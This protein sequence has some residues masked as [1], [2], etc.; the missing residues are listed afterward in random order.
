MDV[1]T[2]C[3]TN[4]RQAYCFCGRAGH[5]RHSYW[6]EQVFEARASEGQNCGSIL[7]PDGAVPGVR[8]E[9]RLR[10]IAFE[11]RDVADCLIEVGTKE[12][13]KNSLDLCRAGFM[14]GPS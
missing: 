11:W 6:C 12:S 1:A 14:A 2:D 4:E 3:R 7:S 13:Y 5:Y 9:A 8:S 10:E